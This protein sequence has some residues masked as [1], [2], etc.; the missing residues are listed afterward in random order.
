[1][2]LNIFTESVLICKNVEIKI[3]DSGALYDWC[4]YFEVRFSGFYHK[5]DILPYVDFEAKMSQI[6]DEISR[7]S[8][9]K[10]TR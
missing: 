9:P 1:M 8:Q 7:L 10:A 3:Y 5:S 6:R 4:W 2:T